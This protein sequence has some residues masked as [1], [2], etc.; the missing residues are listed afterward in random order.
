MDAAWKKKS[1]SGHGENNVLL[2]NPGYAPTR[3]KRGELLGC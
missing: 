2:E 1:T 3:M